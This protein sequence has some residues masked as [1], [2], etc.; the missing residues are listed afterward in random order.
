[1]SFCPQQNWKAIQN[2]WLQARP[3]TLPLLNQFGTTVKANRAL[4]LVFSCPFSPD[5]NLSS[6][7][8]IEEPQAWETAVRTAVMLFTWSNNSEEILV[9]GQLGQRQRVSMLPEGHKA[10]QWQLERRTSEYKAAWRGSQKRTGQS[11]PPP[12][13][14]SA[15]GH[16]GKSWPGAQHWGPALADTKTWSVLWVRRKFTALVN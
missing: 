5:S 8:F 10:C 7:T 16:C 12:L 6:E 4:M 9:D 2:K 1:M 15:L 14:Q 3:A 11:S 13:I